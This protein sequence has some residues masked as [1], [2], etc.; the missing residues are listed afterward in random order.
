MARARNI[1]PS[2][3]I[4]EELVECDFS[5]RLLFIGLWTLAD[6]DGKL[7][8]KPKKIK[9]ALFPADNIN[10]DELLNELQD[11]GFIDRYE[12]EGNQY[13][14]VVAFKKHQNPHRD[15]KAST[16][17]DC[18]KHCASTVQTP[19]KEEL[20]TVSIG[21]NPDSLLLNP[22]SLIAEDAAEKSSA[23]KLQGKALP[24]DW[25]LPKAWGEWAIAE[26][27]EFNAD[28]IRKISES[29]KDHWIA[30]ANQ[31]KA[32]KADWEATWRNWVRNQKANQSYAPKGSI[33]EQNKASTEAA[34]KRLFGTMPTEKEIN[35]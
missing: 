2:F 23:T 20:D 11:R 13:I 4:N 34:K 3:F 7:E 19:C 18:I 1:K 15:E 27:P 35:P 28:Q 8:D 5:T 21:L 33:A 29:F 10:V 16:I 9:M 25:V 30:N 26:R 14:Q 17:P 24:K 22:D 31:A 32:K 12:V 6:R